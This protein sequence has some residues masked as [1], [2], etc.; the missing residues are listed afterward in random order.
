MLTGFNAF[1]MTLLAL[2]M[3]AGVALDW[4]LGE[5]PRWHPLVGFGRYVQ[6]IERQLNRRP[7]SHARGVLAWLLAVL[8]PSPEPP[9]RRGMRSPCR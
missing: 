1:D 3:A 9:L 8:P 6:C 7:G 5:T 2:L 4:L